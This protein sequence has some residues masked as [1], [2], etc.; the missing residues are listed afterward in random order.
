MF[1]LPS[2]GAAA[3]PGL[4][5]PP[6]LGSVR[7]WGLSLLL[8]TPKLL[9]WLSGSAATLVML[10][11]THS[12]KLELH[13]DGNSQAAFLLVWGTSSK[14]HAEQCGCADHHGPATNLQPRRPQ[15]AL[16]TASSG[17]A[18][19]TAPFL[20]TFAHQINGAIPLSRYVFTF[21]PGKT[22]LC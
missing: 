19:P 15:K 13:P 2:Q 7:I 17:P 6:H 3:A 18:I 5:L 21:P 11:T 8:R 4:W 12:R 22:P 20:F 1:P 9:M 10:Q 16:S 14:A